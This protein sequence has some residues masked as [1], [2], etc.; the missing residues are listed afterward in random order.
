MDSNQNIF[1]KNIV[2][3]KGYRYLYDCA[4]NKNRN[5]SNNIYFKLK[6]CVK[7]TNTKKILYSAPKTISI[8][9]WQANLKSVVIN[10]VPVRV[11]LMI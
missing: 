2:M 9:D 4:N 8:N 10:T 1:I 5:Y 6:V 11:R 7:R 3:L